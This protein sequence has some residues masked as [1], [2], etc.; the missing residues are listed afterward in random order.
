MNRA[1]ARGV[2]RSALAAYR[3]EPYHSLLRL[4]DEPDVF[5]REAPDGSR[6]VLEVSAV[7]EFE[8]DGRLLVLAAVSFSFW[9]DFAPVCDDFI[10]AP[11]GSFV[12]EDDA[13]R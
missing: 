8:A 10:V 3:S 7:W 13:S 1:Q 4:L 5:E 9:T 6:Y 11:D 2:A 12:G